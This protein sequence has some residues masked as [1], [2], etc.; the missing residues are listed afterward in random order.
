MVCVCV[1]VT[2]D[3]SGGS[4]TASRVGSDENPSK[5]HPVLVVDIIGP[6]DTQGE[7][8]QLVDVD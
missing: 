1:C 2:N 3:G 5:F 6:L 7:P 4:R 8:L